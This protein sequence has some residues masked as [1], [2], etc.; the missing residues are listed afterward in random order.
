MLSYN[1]MH[2][3]SRLF[4]SGLLYQYRMCRRANIGSVS[5]ISIFVR[6][7]RAR[8]LNMGKASAWAKQKEIGLPMLAIYMGKAERR[9]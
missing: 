9:R 4:V 8:A 7:A 1:D 3:M 2:C 6:C 5:L